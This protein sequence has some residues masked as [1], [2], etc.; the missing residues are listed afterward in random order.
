MAALLA[1][2]SL[3]K[4]TG[5]PVIAPRARDDPGRGRKRS[6]ARAADIFDRRPGDL[7]FGRRRANQEVLPAS[8]KRHPGAQGTRWPTAFHSRLPAVNGV[9]AYASQDLARRAE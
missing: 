2:L 3:D 6:S 5:K 4:S 1:A 9:R 8:L 7:R